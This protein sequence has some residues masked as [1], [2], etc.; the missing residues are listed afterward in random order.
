VLGEV[1]AIIEVAVA[2]TI[3]GIALFGSPAL[4]ER[5]FRL[6]RWIRDRPEPQAPVSGHLGDSG[7]HERRCG[8][9]RRVARQQ[10][11]PQ[12]LPTGW[13]PSLP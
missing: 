2:L 3:I 4:S 6:L 11:K 13:S 5:A 1:I 12:R 9:A 10:Q 8:P 7:V